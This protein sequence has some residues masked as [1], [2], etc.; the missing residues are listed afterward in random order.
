MK[1][2][3]YK[4]KKYVLYLI[5]NFY[6]FIF[7]NKTHLD[8]NNTY[9]WWKMGISDNI[10][11]YGLRDY[12]ALNILCFYNNTSTIISTYRNYDETICIDGCPIDKTVFNYDA[13][14]EFDTHA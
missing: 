7:K 14:L 1:L 11:T 3:Y 4:I 2:K 12:Y 13:I 5:L 10:K 9:F 6:K 8:N